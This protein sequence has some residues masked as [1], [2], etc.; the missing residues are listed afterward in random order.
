[1]LF[2]V[3]FFVKQLHSLS[4]YSDNK[5]ALEDYRLRNDTLGTLEETGVVKINGPFIHVVFYN[6]SLDVN[7]VP[8]NASKIAPL[9]PIVISPHP[10]RLFDPQI[11][12]F[13]SI[14][15]SPSAMKILFPGHI[16]SLT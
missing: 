8:Y 4:I 5:V 10:N 13:P 3:C 9:P 2:F 6:I 12:R 11:G 14:R 7:V 1:M 15:V 16:T